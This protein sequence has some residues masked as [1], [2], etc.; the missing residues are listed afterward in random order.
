MLHGVR[1]LDRSTNIAGPYCAKLLADAGADVVKIEPGGGDPL[2]RWR[3]GK[4][5]EHLNRSKRAAADAEDSF[6]VV[7]ADE[8][9]DPVDVWATHPGAVLVTIT[10]WG[11]TGPWVGRPATEFTLQAWAGSTGTRGYPGSEPIS[12]GGRLGEWVAGTYAGVGAIAALRTG[13]AVHV[14]VALLDC[15]AATMTMMPSIFAS[16]SGWHPAVWSTRSMEV[17]SVEPASD[18]YVNFTT[19]S[20][21]QFSDFCVMIGQG[22]LLEREPK[23]ALAGVRFARRDE[24]ETM[25][26]AFSTPRT[27]DQVLEEAAMFRIPTGP[28]LSGETVL[29]FP[30]FIARGVFEQHDGYL[31]PRVPYRI[32][33][34]STGV[35]QRDR[36]VMSVH[37]SRLGAGK[38]LEGVRVVDLTAWWAGPAAGHGLACLGADVIKVES[39]TRPD[40][41]RYAGV[42]PPTADQW[43]EWGP[44]FHGANTG[45]RGIT[46]DLTRPEG[47]AVLERLIGT[48][49]VVIENYTPR[50]MEQFGLGW[51]RLREVNP[52]VV[53]VRMPAFGLDGP[54]RDHTGFA[55][56][57]ESVS[58][59]AWV[60]GFSDGPPV[61]VRGACDPL[62]GMHAVIATMVALRQ[63]DD[64]GEG[65]MVEATMVEAALN[66]AAEQVIEFSATGAVLSRVGNEGHGA[67][68][69]GVYRCAGEDDWIAVACVDDAQ[70]DALHA[71][72]GPDV[73][74]FAA[75]RQPGALVD[76]LLA[77]GIPAG[78]VVAPRDF[79]QNPQMRHRGLFEMEHHPVSGD[80]E[81]LGLP[82]QLD[83]QPTNA[84]RASPTLGEHNVEV[85]TEIGLTADEIAA[86]EAAGVIG[87]RPTGL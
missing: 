57:M 36:S 65:C 2:R 76:E 73:A 28:V 20:A 47:I 62:A 82:F 7:I 35:H 25:V 27:T 44:M 79:P 49:D 3:S 50:V 61:L 8:V 31:A 78:I 86:L 17:P 66:V 23:M 75:L 41:I 21:Q 40:L 45:K 43:W 81:M 48:A 77:A 70:V 6:D 32:T 53:M 54:W 15:I 85:F 37:T 26:H 24:F 5:F 72:T 63:R 52:R 33:P 19:N 55:Q 1:V 46:L 64:T 56:T 16:M 29:S 51:D 80:H 30:Q 13:R 59:M 83:G 68:S 87:N 71:I 84:G 14:D 74:A 12:V 11:C 10:P 34:A 39:I 38:P 60:T 4:L 18:G 22:D 67:A 9:V 58:G 42:K 69:Q